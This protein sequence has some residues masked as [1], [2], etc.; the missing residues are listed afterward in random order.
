MKRDDA[1][2][3]ETVLA[4]HHHSKHQPDRHAP[5]PGHLDW[6]N[7]PDPFRTHAGAPR[8]QLPLV[9][10]RLTS[11]FDDLYA[12]PGRI[13]VAPVHL[14]SVAALLELSLGLS[15]WKVHG[16][17]RWAL[18]CNP[19]S[20]NLHPTEGYVI[21]PDLPP[22][23]SSPRIEAGVYHYVS[24]DHRLEQRRAI[25]RDERADWNARFPPGS[26]LIGLTSIPWRETWKYGDRAFRY[27]QLDTGHAISA[28]RHAA[29]TLGWRARLLTA[30]AT[31]DVARL[32]GVLTSGV[33]F[34]D[35]GT[36]PEAEEAERL[37][38]VEPASAPWRPL[39]AE[40]VALADL[41]ARG[42]WLGLP[43]RLSRRHG[44]HWPQVEAMTLATLQPRLP[45][46]PPWAPLLETPLPA[47]ASSKGAASLIRQRRSAQ[48]FDPSATLP[49]SALWR[50]LDATLPRADLAPW[51]ALPWA[52]RIFPVCMLHRISGVE[53]GL[54]ILV[55]DPH[56]LDGL[57]AALGEEL[58]WSAVTGAPDHLPL[59]RLRSDSLEETAYWIS[60]QQEIASD[61]VLTLGMLGEF[62]EGLSS[63]PWL[64]RQL[65]QEAGMVG[66]TLYLEAEAAGMRGTG[67]GCFLDDWF[68]QTIGLRS[69]RFQSLYHFTLGRPIVDSRLRTEAP[70][71][72]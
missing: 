62:P 10:D 41:A 21:L 58:A 72:V 49:A 2:P 64:Y 19:S 24:R 3:G 5:G 60:C 33:N 4:Y 1:T 9:A 17:T 56:R 43:N 50:L 68:H 26:L 44:H 32:L 29:A 14:A 37:L 59:Y 66:Q 71:G 7:Q 69:A 52:P 31:R 63:E 51:D 46:P 13:P 42:P 38:L 40:V 55:R 28:F 25:T 34:G 67:I 54:Y 35:D 20:G 11:S 65:Y 16:E 8:I 18:R 45:E 39:G 61:G 36:T 53:A 30:P 27:V 22:E 15:A 57:K 6:A 47:G 12:P 48:R 70:Y 23:G